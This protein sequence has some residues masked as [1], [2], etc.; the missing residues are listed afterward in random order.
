MNAAGDKT[1]ILVVDD[2]PPIRRLLRTNLAVHGYRVLEAGS[3]AE[4]M[5]I[6]GREKPDAVILDLGLPDI[7]GVDVIRRVRAIGSKVPII[8][9]S[10]RDDERGKVQV[11]IPTK[12][13]SDSDLNSPTVPTLSRPLIPRLCRPGART[14]GV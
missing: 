1:P 6:I 5:A 11:P 4:A 7:D 14:A 12:S 9:L 3:G 2:E 10:A 8:V 13:P